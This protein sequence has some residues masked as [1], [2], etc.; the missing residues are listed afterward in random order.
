MIFSNHDAVPAAKTYLGTTKQVIECPINKLQP[1]EFHNEHMPKQKLNM[2]NQEY[3]NT[4]VMI[5]VRDKAVIM[6][7]MKRRSYV[8]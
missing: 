6:G 8:H 2:N 1:I 3:N 5:N 4:Y 7:E